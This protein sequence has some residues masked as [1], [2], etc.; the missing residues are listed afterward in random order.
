MS[1]LL[2]EY[3]KKYH[4]RGEEVSSGLNRASRVGSDTNDGIPT[5]ANQVSSIHSAGVTLAGVDDNPGAAY[6]LACTETALL[7]CHNSPELTETSCSLPGMCR[8]LFRLLLQGPDG[9]FYV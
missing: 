3:S 7:L 5:V 4:I 6:L 8:S 9:G 1:T 2:L